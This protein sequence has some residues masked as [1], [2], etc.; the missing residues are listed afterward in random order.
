MQINNLQWKIGGQAGYGIMSAGE[1]FGKACTRAGL[2]AFATNDYP[3]LVRGGSNTFTIRVKETPFSTYLSKTNLLVALNKET[4][5]LYK[6]ELTENSA[7]IYDENIP[8]EEKD[9]PNINLFP[10]PMEKFA[11][12]F[13]YADVMRNTVA[14]GASFG[15]LKL[16]FQFLE[17]VIKDIFAKK[18][19]VIEPNISAA[20]AGYD[21]LKEKESHYQ[22]K[23][24]QA[25]KQLFISGNHAL[26]LGSIKAG[27]KFAP[28]YPIT[29]INPLINYLAL[30]S[31]DHNFIV[32]TPEDEISGIL[33]TIGASHTGARS[34]VATSGAGFSLMTESL[35]LAGITETPL[36][37][38]YG[39]RAGPATGMPT[40]TEQSDLLF[41]KN[42]A[43]GEFPRIIIA[44]GDVQECFEETLRAFQLAEKYQLPV[45]VLT[46]KF[47]NESIQTI[48]NLTSNIQ[49]KRES[50]ATPKQDFKRYQFTESG[51]SPRSIPGQENGFFVANSDEH[52]EYGYSTS[53]PEIR[54]KMVDKRFKKLENLKLPEPILHGN[55]DARTM[56]IS[57]GS[58][59]G[60]ILEALEKFDNL[61]FLQLQYLTPFP[62]ITNL[63][64]NKQLIIIENNRTNQLAKLIQQNTLIKPQH[65]IN[66]YDGFQFT[67]DQIEEELKKCL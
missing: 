18:P 23:P 1:I 67:A 66:K 10:I 13:G 34:M 62:D 33:Q 42:A 40:K 11:Q 38:L 15:L 16:D 64:K 57:W 30:K 46:D 45:I 44:P 25:Q 58:T 32:E 6:H 35:A 43:H 51:I 65:L 4:I 31:K 53:D 12:E 5:D 50:F 8:L 61:N 55:P 48:P 56:I 63:I 29:P 49:I 7:I 27:L 36:V 59:K 41:V 26:A 28:I 47:L 39:Q 2:N 21:F 60:A 20:K 22:L 9:F 14:I 24:K 17:G 54:T 52:D 37:I 19:K 3:S